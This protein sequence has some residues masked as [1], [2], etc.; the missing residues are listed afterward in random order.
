MAGG[1]ALER[2]V[3]EFHPHP[4]ALGSC[5]RTGGPRPDGP[6][7]GASTRPAARGS[8]ARQQPVQERLPIH[9]PPASCRSET[10]IPRSSGGRSSSTAGQLTFT[11]IPTTIG[12]GDPG[13]PPVRSASARTPA[14]FRP[15][16]SDQVVRPLDPDLTG[17]P[18]L[19]LSTRPVQS[20]I[21]S[22][23][24]GHARSWP[25][26]ARTDRSRAGA[27]PRQA[28]SPR[29]APP[30]GDRV[31]HARPSGGR[32]PPPRPRGHPARASSSR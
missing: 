7:P 3:G 21:A 20:R 14:S 16:A 19:R 26:D 25:D 9:S 15:S 6:G 4:G 17:T 24:E 22:S 27:G 29:P 2:L 28:G 1:R 31:V 10:A 5:T 8:S 11:P 30:S 23:G 12:A 13:D 32:R 18:P